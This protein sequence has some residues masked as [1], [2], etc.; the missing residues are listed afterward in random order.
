MKKVLI[1]TIVRDSSKYLNNWINQIAKLS[2]EIKDD[3][4]IY[5]SV[6]END[7]IDGSDVFLKK[8]DQ[9]LTGNYHIITTEKIGTL[10]YPSIWNENRIKNLANARQ[11]CL[12]QANAKWG[13]STFDKI[14]YIEPDVSYDPAW[15][16]ELI[17]ARH[18]NQA[19]LQEPDIYSGYSLRVESHPKESIFLYDT[20]A[21][22]KTEN[23]ISWSFSDDENWRAKSLIKT[24][25]SNFDNNCLHSIWSTFNC[26]CVYNAD[27]FI[28]GLRWNYIN[29][30]LDTGQVKI[31]GGWLDADTVVI[32]EDFRKNNY[33]KIYLNTNC[34]IRH[35][36]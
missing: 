25:F 11:K 14:A 33:N 30:R 10:K 19:G 13:L 27:P 18:P 31:E 36:N 17:I 2:L 7:S 24:N 35:L 9:K 32:C 22:R 29:K 12:D 8:I 3:Y 6:Y 1:C 34:L 28:N 16:K 23:D 26:F 20:C 15:C 21:T 4:I 5:L